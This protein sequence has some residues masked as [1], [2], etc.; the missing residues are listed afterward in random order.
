M[1]L[2]PRQLPSPAPTPGSSMLPQPST[3]DAEPIDQASLRA[4][5]EVQLLKLSQDL[6]EL[7]ICAGDVG[8][9]MEDA[10]PNYLMKVNQGFINLERIA[11]QLGESV[12]HQIVEHIDRYKRWSRS[13]CERGIS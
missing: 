6:Y 7:E 1:S 12:P 11:G 3:S 13:P 8:Q 5:L 2:A 4:E 10:V 9:G